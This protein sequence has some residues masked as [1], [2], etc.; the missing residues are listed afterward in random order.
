[1]D[2]VAAL[3]GVPVALFALLL[4]HRAGLRRAEHE[5]RRRQLAAIEMG[6]SIV[7]GLSAAKWSLESGDVGR[8][9]DIIGETLRVGNA[10][11]ADLVREADLTGVWTGRR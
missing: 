11:L 8:G 2:A 10:S 6:D 9:L 7:Q 1:V 4:G 5:R 3:T